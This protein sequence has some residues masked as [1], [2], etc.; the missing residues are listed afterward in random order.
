MRE[1]FHPAPFVAHVR[2][3]DI[4][5]S[6]E[7]MQG[8]ITTNADSISSADNDRLMVRTDKKVTIKILDKLHTLSVEDNEIKFKEI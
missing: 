3:L 5:G 2:D 8:R 6:I 7:D 1:V 4:A